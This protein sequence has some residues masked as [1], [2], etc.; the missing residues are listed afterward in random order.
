[1]IRSKHRDTCDI[2][3]SIHLS[4][5]CCFS[6][7][8]S[9]TRL[10]VILLWLVTSSRHLPPHNRHSLGI[11]SLFWAIFCKA[12]RCLS[13]KIPADQQLMKSSERPI[14][15]KHS[16]QSRWNPF[17]SSIWRS[18]STS[19]S[20][21]QNADTPKGTESMPRDWL[22]NALA[23][24]TSQLPMLP[25]EGASERYFACVSSIDSCW[26]WW[27]CG[28]LMT[29]PSWP[30]S[31][32][33]SHTGPVERSHINH[34]NQPQVNLS[35]LRILDV[36]SAT[37]CSSACVDPEVAVTPCQSKKNQTLHTERKNLTFTSPLTFI[38]AI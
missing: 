37:G 2:F 16:I 26:C 33:L 12:R 25:D 36:S 21:L 31:V 5:S 35:L 24:W 7:S 23:V 28:R 4:G 19:A 1:M 20:R 29:L 34:I 22:L 18:L 13:V 15:Y 30:P 6:V 14:W 38:F 27:V 17:P 9:L 10:P 32:L 11:L 8:L 3:I